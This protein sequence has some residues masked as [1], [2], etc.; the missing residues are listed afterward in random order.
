MGTKPESVDAQKGTMLDIFAR[1]LKKK[2]AQVCTLHKYCM[3][4]KEDS[5]P[6]IILAATL[7]K[8][9]TSLYSHVLQQP[10]NLQQIAS[11]NP[12]P[13]YICALEFSCNNRCLFFRRLKINHESHEFIL[14]SGSVA[15]SLDRTPDSLYRTPYSLYRTSAFRHQFFCTEHPNFMLSTLYILNSAL[16]T[17]SSTLNI[18]YSTLNILYSTLNILYSTLNILY[19]T[20]NILYSTLNILPAQ[21]TKNPVQHNKHFL[22]PSNILSGTTKDLYK[23]SNNILLTANILYSCTGHHIFYPG[24]PT[25]CTDIKYSVQDIKH[26]VQDTKYSSNIQN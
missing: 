11:W 6:S 9:L 5:Q 24:H 4:V 21:H 23:V 8:E 10:V 16:K 3:N 22:W 20:L 19:S 12:F 26:Y 14:G 17:L 2:I 1:C 25:L 15:N 18:L 7:P 13:V